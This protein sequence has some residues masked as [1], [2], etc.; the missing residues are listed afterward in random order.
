LDPDPKQ[1]DMKATHEYMALGALKPRNIRPRN[2]RL[3]IYRG[4]LTPNDIYWRVVNGIDG[5]PMPGLTMKPQNEKGLSPD[6]VWDLVEYVR[7][8]PYEALN[9]PDSSQPTIARDRM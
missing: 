4:G 3:G 1:I 8:L 6:D 7:S 9:K 5:T 2:L